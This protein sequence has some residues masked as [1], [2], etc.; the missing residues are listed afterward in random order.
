MNRLDLYL[1]FRIDGYSFSLL[2]KEKSEDMHSTNATD[3]TRAD[4]FN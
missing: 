4:C 1:F 2:H 3:P